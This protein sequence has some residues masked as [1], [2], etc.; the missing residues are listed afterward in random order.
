MAIQGE[1]DMQIYIHTYAYNIYIYNIYVS[2]YLCV[3]LFIC[4]CYNI[5]R[6][7]SEATRASINQEDALWDVRVGGRAWQRSSMDACAAICL[8]S[9]LACRHCRKATA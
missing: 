9:T 1:I 2:I 6:L 4:I 7:I 8:R 5:D 3:Y